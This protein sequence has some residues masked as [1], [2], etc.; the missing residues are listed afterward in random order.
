MP[1]TK[2]GQEGTMPT[3]R[4]DE[5]LL[6]LQAL[7]KRIQ[8]INDRQVR[9]DTLVQV[10]LGTDGTLA[11]LKRKVDGNNTRILLLSA[12]PGFCRRSNT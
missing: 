10:H 8:L 6:L 5:M 1:T 12:S 9:S 4:L 11:E 7:D 2:Q 3:A